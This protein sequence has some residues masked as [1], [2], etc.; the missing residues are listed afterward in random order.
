MK[1]WEALKAA[2]ED[3]AKIR[4]PDW[5]CDYTYIYWDGKSLVDDNGD[6]NWDWNFLAT[7]NDWEIY[8]EPKPKQTWYRVKWIM[9]KYPS[10]SPRSARDWYK[11]KDLAVGAWSG[12][13]DHSTA[14]FEELEV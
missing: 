12:E 6:N 2:Q 3:G 13:W 4:R 1:F 7:H 10:Y 5:G 8:Q 11:S 14:I 9:S